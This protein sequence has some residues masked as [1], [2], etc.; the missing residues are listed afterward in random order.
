MRAPTKGGPKQL[1]KTRG[2]ATRRKRAYE[3]AERPRAA[4]AT[5]M[6]TVG[7]H[8]I[9]TCAMRSPNTAVAKK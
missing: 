9:E 7:R 1:S 8:S 2:I 6:A 3:R 5:P 4:R